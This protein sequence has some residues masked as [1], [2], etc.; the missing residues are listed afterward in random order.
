MTKE[1]K[2]KDNIVKIIGIIVGIIAFV[3]LCIISV[4]FYRLNRPIRI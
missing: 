1:E 4:Y 2:K 3:I